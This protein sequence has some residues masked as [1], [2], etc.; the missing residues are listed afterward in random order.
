MRKKEKTIKSPKVLR[1]LKNMRFVE[2]RIVVESGEI[3]DYYFHEIEQITLRRDMH[4]WERS[5]GERTH[6]VHWTCEELGGGNA[7][8]GYWLAKARDRRRYMHSKCTK[9]NCQ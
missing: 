9:G 8:I 1:N 5:N 2:R 4:F 3:R 6:Y 7:G